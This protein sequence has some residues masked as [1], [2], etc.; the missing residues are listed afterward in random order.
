M[1]DKN[2]APFGFYAVEHRHNVQQ[3]SPC[4]DCDFW[5]SGTCGRNTVSCFLQNRADDRSVV[6]K[7]RWWFKPIVVAMVIIHR[8]RR[9]Q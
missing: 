9:K 6:F 3:S 5:S 8:L 4:Y 1:V 2:E 7:S